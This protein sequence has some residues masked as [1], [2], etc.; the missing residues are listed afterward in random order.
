M[1]TK[2]FRALCVVIATTALVLVPSSLSASDSR[3]A[4]QA[5]AGDALEVALAYVNA[6]PADLGVTSADVSDLRATSTLRS[7]HSGVTHVNL[8]QR[9]QGLEVFGGHATVNVPQT[10]ASSS[11]PAPSCATCVP[12]GRRPPLDAADAVEAAAAGLDL[13]EPANLRILEEGDGEALVSSGGISTCRD[14]GTARLAADAGRAAPRLAGHDRRLRRRAPLERGGGRRDGQ[15]PG[16]DGL[17]EPRHAREPEHAVPRRRA[18]RSSRR[19]ASPVPAEPRPRRVELP[20]L[21]LPTESPNDG[22]RALV[23]NPADGL[24]SPFGWHDTNGAAGPEFTI[25]RGNNAHAYLDQDDNERQD[26]GSDARRRRGSRLRLPGRPGG[27]RA[28]LQGR[29][30]HEPLLR[31]QRVPRH[32][33]P[34]RVRRGVGQLPGQQL[35]PRRPGGDYVRCEAADGSGTNNANFSTPAADGAGAPRMQM[36]LWPGQPVRA[37]EP[38]RHR[39]HRRTSAPAGR[40]SARRPRTPASAARSCSSTTGRRVRDRGLRAARRL[41]GRGDRAR[42]PRHLHV[43]AGTIAETRAGRRRDRGHHRQQRGRQRA[44][45]RAARS[46]TAAGPT[47]P[48]VSVTQTDGAAIKAVAARRRA[49]SARTRRHPGHPRRRPRERDHLPR[50]RPRRLQP[51]H[52]RPRDRQLPQRQRAGGRGLERLPRHHGDLLD[53]ALD[54]PDG[55]AGWAR[56]RSSSRPARATGIRPRPYSR[57][58]SIQPFTYDSIKTDGWLNG[59]SLALPHGLGHGWA[60][61]AV[62]PQLGSHRQVRVQPEHLRGLEHGR[63]QPRDP[64]RHR[65]AE[66]AGLRP[67]PRRR[68]PG[69]HR[70]RGR[71][72]ERRGHLHGLGHVRAPRARL[73]RRPGDDE[74]RRQHRGVRHASGLPPR[75]PEPGHTAVRHAERG[76]RRRRG[77]AEVHG[78]RLQGP[79]RAREQWLAV[80]PPGGLRD[81]A[82][83]ELGA[84]S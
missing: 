57:D 46:S 51:P 20:R 49:P 16:F 59:T 27:A 6:N 34:L 37:P 29:R 75:V 64:V 67:R 42:R 32:P 65:R 66:D 12:L 19:L 53:P 24:A 18:R 48:T 79:G 45:H 10:A 78:G 41:P 33:L 55:R 77:A 30:R 54:D 9:F 56:T 84:R 4:E 61:D 15:A 80:L 72:H 25:T 47:I 68:A 83:A 63:E 82:G 5:A 69:D 74:P 44:D 31:L 3:A 36:F 35:R 60:A 26:F 76:R 38:G 13:A 62:G 73:Q 39:R 8:N 21:Q 2:S 7:A 50:V 81:A 28:V 22:P 11:P 40:G 58:M 52:R 71:A 43:P 17:D 1:T 23:D 14:P 70:R